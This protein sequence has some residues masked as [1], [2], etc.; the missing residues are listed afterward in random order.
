[1]PYDAL[2]ISG[3]VTELNEKL[4]NG[5]VEQIYHPLKDRLELEIYH[6]YPGV[7]LRLLLSAH[8]QFARI[9]LTGGKTENPMHPSAFCMLL[10]KHLSGG[11]ILNVDQTPWERIINITI[12]VYATEKGLCQ[13]RLVLEALGRRS[14]VILLEENNTIIDAL[15]R[16]IGEREIFPGYSYVPPSSPSPYSPELSADE[17]QIILDRVP[18]KKPLFET[19]YSELLGVSPFLGR[20]WSCRA[21]FDPNTSAGSL[22]DDA[23]ERLKHAWFKIMEEKK[24]PKPCLVLNDSGKIMDFYLFEPTQASLIPEPVSDLNQAVLETLHLWEENA[25]IN[26]AQTRLQRIIGDRINK[27]QTKLKKQ[28]EE[29]CAAEDAQVYRIRGELLSIHQNSIVKG[30]PQVELPNYYDP[31]GK[32]IIIPLRMDL[33]PIENAQAYFKKYQKS[34]KGRKAIAHQIQLTTDD[35]GYLEGIQAMLTDSMRIEELA[36]I[37]DELKNY[38][39]ISRHDNTTSKSKSPVSTPRRFISSEGIAIDVGRN[40]LQNDRLTLKIASPR[41]TWLHTQNIP[42]SHILIRDDGQGFGESTLLEAANLAA[43]FSKARNSTKVPVDYT[44]RRNV[45][46]PAGSRPGFVLYEPFQTIIV[47]PNIELLKRLGVD[48]S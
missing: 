7:N 21:G 37:E 1:M 32:T 15:K 3:F 39:L 35:L 19:L 16:T 25:K 5:R 26:S 22:P 48:A 23:G 14:N 12:E 36:E 40:N 44:M 2:F 10:R 9:N 34:K 18:A 20:E 8:T 42:G 28:H 6:P 11:R 38:G 41:D 30:Q 33:S 4:R 47:T 13:K 29:L 24:Y 45:R 43:W 31:E 27:L 46:K 17:L